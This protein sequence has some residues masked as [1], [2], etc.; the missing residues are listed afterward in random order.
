MKPKTYIK[1]LLL[2]CSLP[3]F[4]LNFMMNDPSLPMGYGT[5][6]FL[7]LFGLYTMMAPQSW[8][9]RFWVRHC[10]EDPYDM[11]PLLGAAALVL[12]ILP[13]MYLMGMYVG[14]P[15]FAIFS[16]PIITGVYELVLWLR[17]RS[18]LR[19]RDMVCGIILSVIFMMMSLRLGAAFLLTLPLIGILF[20]LQFYPFQSR[21]N[22]E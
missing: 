18:A 16:F 3:Y 10:Q 6:V 14:L 9:V 4:I 17:C 11:A 1:L 7:V 20:F 5:L 15:E 19:I 2:V 21:R 12:T 22:K 8:Y 13:I